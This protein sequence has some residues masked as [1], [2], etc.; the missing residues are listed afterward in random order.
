VDTGK[1]V[2]SLPRYSRRLLVGVRLLNLG[3]VGDAGRHSR[4]CREALSETVIETHGRPTRKGSYAVLG[5]ERMSELLTVRDVAGVLKCS[6]DAVVKKFAKVPGVIDLGRAETRNRRR[7][8]VLRIPRAVLEK[9]L[10]TKSGHP[11]KVEVPVR[12]ER[13]RKSPNWE[14]AAILNL[15]KAGHQNDC[16]DRAAYR[17]IADMARLLAA[18]VPESLWSEVLEGRLDDED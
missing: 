18:K 6:E 16:E 17:T 13:R 2:T 11:V 1:F 14:D 8:R 3:S 4:R 10:A 9:Y 5:R 7:Y 12:P 15:A